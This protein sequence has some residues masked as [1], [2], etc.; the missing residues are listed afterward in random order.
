MAPVHL[1]LFTWRS[2]EPT[3]GDH[4]RSL[5]LRPQPIRQQR[6]AAR[7]VA[8][9]QFPQQDPRVP[10]AR[11]QP[12][13]QVSLERLQLANWRR[14]SCINRPSRWCQQI[15]PDRLAVVPSQVTDCLDADSIP[16]QLVDLFH[17]SSP[18]HMTA[19]LWIPESGVAPPV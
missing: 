13:L 18:K 14:S 11:L 4:T 6:V 16:F 10:D 2:F 8:R 15:L 9:A 7:V 17:V 5:T 3:H 1:G 19:L 12:L